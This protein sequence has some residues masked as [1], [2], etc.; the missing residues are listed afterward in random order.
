V[1]FVT[2]VGALLFTIEKAIY[3]LKK[4]IEKESYIQLEKKIK[5][6]KLK[7]KLCTD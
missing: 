3:S 5:T 6:K 2:R 4:K 7:R 1:F